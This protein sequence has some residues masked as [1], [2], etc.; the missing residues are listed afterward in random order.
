MRSNAAPVTDRALFVP[1]MA[2]ARDSRHRGADADV[3]WVTFNLCVVADRHARGLPC[4]DL[5]AYLG[6]VEPRENFDQL[7]AEFSRLLVALDAAHGRRLNHIEGPALSWY[8]SLFRY[9]GLLEYAGLVLFSRALTRCLEANHIRHLHMIGAFGPGLAALTGSEYLEVARAVCLQVG[10]DLTI[11]EAG[12]TAVAD[13]AGAARRLR[14]FAWSIRQR[15]RRRSMTRGS[16]A[17]STSGTT[18]LV[19][20]LYEAE[21]LPLNRASVC[22]WPAGGPRSRMAPMNH[23]APDP[24]VDAAVVEAF[25]DLPHLDLYVPAMTMHVERSRPACDRAI[26]AV[27]ALVKDRGV[28]QAVWGTSPAAAGPDTL[29]VEWLR[30]NKIRVVGVQHGGSY[31]DQPLDAMHLLSDYLYCDE[32]LA[33]GAQPRDLSA[34]PAVGLSPAA[35]VAVGSLKEAARVAKSAGGVPHR[36]RE[37]LDILFPI[38]LAHDLATG[39]PLAKGD[40]MRARQVAIIRHLEGVTARVVIKPL[41]RISRNAE[42]LDRYFPAHVDLQSV[43]HCKVDESCSYEEAIDRYAPRLV[44]FDWF[45]TTLQE[46]LAHDV[47]ILQ[48]VDPVC[49]PKPAIRQLLEERIHWADGVPELL[50]LVDRF[51]SGGLDTRRGTAYYREFVA[52]EG[53]A[54]LAAARHLGWSA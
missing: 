8:F 9:L 15:Y 11:D 23:P 4:L 43:R 3:P 50:T 10:T 38:S 22:V 39:V 32:F 33:Y 49:P 20:P 51:L 7:R 21:H 54:V 45:S 19:E 28:T 47:E 44:I 30:R 24:A 6:P 34:A 16:G 52:P 36:R 26:A 41:R 40:E 18:M 2:A 53:D 12:T 46:S 1:T 42:Y 31:G 29:V 48:L 27:S 14:T 35:I 37:R 17:R 5:H 13:R 25:P